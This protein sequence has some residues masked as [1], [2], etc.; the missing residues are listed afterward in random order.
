VKRGWL[1][2]PIAAAAL[3][4]V[5]LAIAFPHRMVS[6]GALTAGHAAIENDCFACHAPW[7]GAAS[8]RCMRCHQPADVGVRT[9][10]GVPLPPRNVKIAFHREL[11]DQDC[12]ACHSD[13]AGPKRT[14]RS[15]KPFS[16]EL[17]RPAARRLCGGC[18][19][20]PLDGAHRDLT[21]GCARCH[22][23]DGWKPADFDHA[24]LVAAEQQH[25]EG[26]H[27]PPA[28]GVHRPI[29]GY[30]QQCH[31]TRRW[32]PPT[33][34]HDKVFVL[35]ADH[36]TACATCHTGD[37]YRRYSCYGCHAHRAAGIRAIHLDEGI[38]HFDD[39]AR[40][41]RSASGEAEGGRD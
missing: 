23:P 38:R 27:R 39:C 19:A 21:V 14:E 35:D 10:L 15:R 40:C 24:R 12:M 30:C 7:R 32:D 1:L 18:H 16:H 26:C 36:N 29:K 25:C 17:L 37:D 9:T 34:D 8:Q 4:V 11:I 13:H 6:P 5:V 22:K 33:F 2:A 3:A 31:S 28:D 41:H 20:A